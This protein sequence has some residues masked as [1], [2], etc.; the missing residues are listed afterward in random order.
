MLQFLAS[1]G[2]EINTQENWKSTPL[3]WAAEKGQQAAVRLLLGLGADRSLKN[4]MGKTVEEVC[5]NDE[6]TRAVFTEISDQG[7]ET[8]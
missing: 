7:M 2:A 1:R 6:E 5:K 3:H 8:D 4:N